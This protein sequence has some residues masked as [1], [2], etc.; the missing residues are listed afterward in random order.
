MAGSE[1]LWRVGLVCGGV[2]LA[3]V[4]LAGFGVGRGFEANPSGPPPQATASVATAAG[5]IVRA[6]V[7][8]QTTDPFYLAGG[9]Y[10]SVWSAWGEAPE[11]PPCTHS[12]KLMAVD[13][14]NA[15]TSLGNVIDLATRVQVPATGTSNSS[16]VYDVKPGDYYLDVTSACAWQIAISPAEHPSAAAGSS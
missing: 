7:G 3:A 4:V 13:P 14:A 8:S 12:A 10:G 2:A 16:Y 6:G 9:T 1:A 11:F 15:A 5:P